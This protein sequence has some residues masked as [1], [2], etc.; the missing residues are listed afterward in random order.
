MRKGFEYVDY[1]ILALIVAGV[2]Y[3][4]VRR[5]RRR[6]APAGVIAESSAADEP[7]TAGL[8]AAEERPAPAEQ[9]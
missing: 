9:G 1:A 3:A 5:R 2:A 8:V 4:I 6:A 7:A